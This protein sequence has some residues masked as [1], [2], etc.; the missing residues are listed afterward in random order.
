MAEKMTDFR[1]RL[2]EHI[3]DDAEFRKMVEAETGTP[4]KVSVNW[5]DRTVTIRGPKMGR[6]LGLD[7]LLD[8]HK[9]ETRRQ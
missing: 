4:V 9:T 3:F 2:I 6:V 8:A 1:A 7:E 5:E